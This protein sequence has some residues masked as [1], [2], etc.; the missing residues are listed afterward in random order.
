MR[1]IQNRRKRIRQP[2]SS[3]PSGRRLAITGYLDQILNKCHSDVPNHAYGV[4]NPN[5]FSIHICAQ[6]PQCHTD[7]SFQIYLI[8]YLTQPR[9]V[10][11]A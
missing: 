4:N 6:D 11:A 5:T 7:S 3:K 8:P 2:V 10:S 9:N 1:N